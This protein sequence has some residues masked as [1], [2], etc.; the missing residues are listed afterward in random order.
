MQSCGGRS[1]DYAR[2]ITRTVFRSGW[3]FQALPSHALQL[4]R[5]ADR[6]EVDGGVVRA[7]A[8]DP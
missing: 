8:D 2:M 5:R 3:Y 1:G 7:A 4:D 6:H